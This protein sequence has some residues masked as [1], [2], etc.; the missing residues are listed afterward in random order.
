MTLN[1]T[2]KIVIEAIEIKSY[3][4]TK[5]LFEF[6]DSS[7]LTKPMKQVQVQIFKFEKVH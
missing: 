1:G 6:F 3:Y 4:C 7:F 5:P 2:Q